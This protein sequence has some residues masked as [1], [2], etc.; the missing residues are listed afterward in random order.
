MIT[1]ENQAYITTM[2]ESNQGI[3]LLDLLLSQEE[4]IA[5]DVYRS[6]LNGSIYVDLHRYPLGEPERVPV[7]SNEYQSITLAQPQKY[8]SL[9]TQI[10]IEPGA[11]VMWAENPFTIVNIGDGIIWLQN[12]HSSIIKMAMCD[13]E[14]MVDKG[15]ITGVPLATLIED[16]VLELLKKMSPADHKR[17]LSRKDEL[18]GFLSGV[19]KLTPGRSDYRW[20]KRYKE[21][22]MLFGSGLLGL[23][24][25]NSHKGNK[26]PRLHEDSYDLMD[27]FIEDQ[28]L[29]LEQSNIRTAHGQYVKVCDERGLYK[30]S[31]ET[32]RNRIEK[33]KNAEELARKRK[34]KRPA[35][36]LKPF[37]IELTYT[38]PRH[39]ERPFEIAH[40]DHTLL[41]IELINPRTLENL[42][43]PWL[44]LMIDAY[45]RRILAFYIS[46][47]PPS[48]RSCMN[49]TR[50]C[51]LRHKCLPQIIF[52]DNGKEFKSTYFEVLIASKEM[53]K[54]ERPPAQSRFGSVMERMFN[55]TNTEFI[56]TLQGN[57]QIMREVRE[58]TISNNPKNRA[59]WNLAKL[60]DKLSEYLYETYDS[61]YHTGI[62]E[63]PRD[64]FIR[65]LFLFGKRRI[66]PLNAIQG[67]IFSML[68]TTVLGEATVVQ[69]QG[70]KINKIYYRH[71]A[72]NSPGVVGTKVPVKYDPFNLGHAYAYVGNTWIECLS[73]YYAQFKDLTEKEL[74]VISAQLE[75]EYAISNQ[76]IALTT[77][78]IAAFIAT[79]KDTE[80][81]LIVQKLAS[82]QR[83]LHG[84]TG[85]II[86]PD[87][88]ES[89]TSHDIVEW[90]IDDDTE[91]DEEYQILN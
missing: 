56:H 54:K 51:G 84:F 60:T 42:G 63:S 15:E 39:G 18:A 32:F 62:R 49:V 45:S 52:V 17:A 13:F 6:I 85:N 41:D 19:E 9:P 12:E 69:S 55:T 86:K 70:V 7:F 50:I 36:K 44:T 14:S 89:A 59:I 47:E 1:P 34:G 4:S 79:T 3:M 66:I 5:N 43:R 73:E 29:T 23:Y 11:G 48:Y 53:T 10:L 21:A 77:Q 31:Y 61:K 76:K 64:A 35:Y 90:G 82:E 80:K 8:L 67:F 20:I 2:V 24:D 74:Q 16:A 46:F 72:L 83:G 33:T 38:T 68:P 27:T 71:E 22:E 75:A 37:Y 26:K 65:G 91:L 25:K 28:H 88:P 81:E 87:R 58:V 57:T 30:V 78:R 40:I